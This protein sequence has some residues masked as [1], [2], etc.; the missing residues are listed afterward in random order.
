[1]QNALRREQNYASC[2]ALF[3][4]KCINNRIEILQAERPETETFSARLSK[5]QSNLRNQ[6]LASSSRKASNSA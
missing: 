6:K 2:S 5:K 1:L 4:G 3:G